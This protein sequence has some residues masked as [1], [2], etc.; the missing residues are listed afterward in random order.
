MVKNQL[1]KVIS[2][3]I[4]NNRLN[5]CYLLKSYQDNNFDNAILYIINS[6]NSTKIENLNL[7]NLPDNILLLDPNQENNALTKDNILSNFEKLYLVNDN[8]NKKFLIFKNIEFA[9]INALNALLK[10][11]EEPSTDVIFIFTTQNIDKVLSTIKSRSVII[12]IPEKNKEDLTAKLKDMGFNEHECY[13]LSNVLVSENEIENE[14]ICTIMDKLLDQ[15]LLAIK[16]PYYLYAY[17]IQFLNKNL[18]NE[19]FILIK[20]LRFYCQA[21]IEKHLIT[22]EM[23]KEKLAKLKQAKFN[24][25]EIYLIT[26][27]FIKQY[28]SNNNQY[29]Q[30]EKMFIK[31]VENYV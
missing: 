21:I 16:N 20:T 27:A 2:N 15:M 4:K 3:S 7:E 1:E 14:N 17:L 24:Y 5:H 30:A 12:N 13:L 29:L 9:S 11:I 26:N 22:D 25:T 10:T 6:L 23:V 31:I 19:L 8:K 18:N 28:F